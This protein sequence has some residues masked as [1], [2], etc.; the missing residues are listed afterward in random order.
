[1]KVLFFPL[2]ITTPHYET[3]LELILTHILK[4][5]EVFC[6][7]CDGYL[8]TCLNNFYAKK[9]YCEIC[10]SVVNTGLNTIGFPR[11][12]LLKLPIKHELLEPIPPIFKNLQELIHYTYDGM[13]LGRVTA[14]N[15]TITLNWEHRLDTIANKEHV[16]RI[17][18]NTITIYSGML[19]ILK[20]ISPDLVY[21][22][23]GRFGQPGAV[24]FACE[25]LG[26]N[27]ITHERAGVL[28]KY[29]LREGNI[30]HDIDAAVKE[31]NELTTLLKNEYGIEPAVAAAAVA[32]VSMD[33]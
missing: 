14:A 11:K 2:F 30:P 19:E 16:S 31:I 22:F 32:A 28:E 5:D 8:K 25:K 21:I 18:T 26:I 1:M 13:N 15:L 29:W 24:I 4:G 7:K 6:I 20:K 23:N 10:R 9:S 27:Y 33:A 3:E 17:L 12:N